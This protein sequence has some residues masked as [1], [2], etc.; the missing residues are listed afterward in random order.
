MTI[1]VVT[2]TSGNSGKST[3]AKHW[4]KP[5]MGQGVHCIS[6]F[7]EETAAPKGFADQEV[8]KRSA[9]EDVAIRIYGG[10]ADTSLLIDMGSSRVNEINRFWGQV[11]GLHKRV[12]HFVL[13]FQVTQKSIT[14]T[15]SSAFTLL[16][17]G[18]DAHKIV[19]VPN[20]IRTTSEI[21]CKTFKTLI[22]R[23]VED[24]EL[25][26]IATPI[27]YHPF[28][29]AVQFHDCTSRQVAAYHVPRL[30]IDATADA[31]AERAEILAFRRLARIAE[32]NLEQAY[33][34]LMKLTPSP[35]R[36][37]HPMAA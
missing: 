36:H 21:E 26:L 27:R 19:L 30:S 33:A 23:P 22:A 11:D 10:M 28:F 35:L 8:H 14:D 25:S 18:V 7:H 6:M 17:M 31:I 1:I 5:R 2:N 24:N 32:K 20:M 9:T 34:D 16:E 29:D 4:L 3:L 12:D 15:I 13:P 37:E